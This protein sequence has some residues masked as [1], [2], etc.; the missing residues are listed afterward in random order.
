M[1][2]FIDYLQCVLRVFSSYFSLTESET[3]GCVSEDGTKWLNEAKVMQ[4]AQPD[5]FAT[6][7][8]LIVAR[9]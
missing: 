6:V 5:T 2:E 9:A 1:V 3:V 8:C 4:A 7:L